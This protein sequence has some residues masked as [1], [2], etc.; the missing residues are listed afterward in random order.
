[1]DN[2][3]GVLVRRSGGGERRWLVWRAM[4]IAGAVRGCGLDM[5]GFVWELLVVCFAQV[6]L[7]FHG[8]YL[9]ESIGVFTDIRI[10]RLCNV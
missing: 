9:V 3:V 10:D 6:L 4:G 7:V 5:T 8:W 1:M 2:V